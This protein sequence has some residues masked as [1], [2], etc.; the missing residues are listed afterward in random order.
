MLKNT[1]TIL[2]KKYINQYLV[3]LSYPLTPPLMLI[4]YLILLY[5][6]HVH[7][8]YTSW[9]DK[10]QAISQQQYALITQRKYLDQCY[11]SLKQDSKIAF[12]VFLEGDKTT[13]ISSDRFNNI[14]HYLLSHQLHIEKYTSSDNIKQNSTQTYWVTGTYLN[15]IQALKN[16]NDQ[17]F[18][19]WITSLTLQ[20]NVESTELLQLQ[21]SLE[22]NRD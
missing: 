21:L 2:K 16:W 20:S 18:L 10:K 9:R 5:L 17:H 22:N 6:L 12:N 13:S 8:A 14:Q 11:R 3:I 15:I 19:S 4:I 7:S 1:I